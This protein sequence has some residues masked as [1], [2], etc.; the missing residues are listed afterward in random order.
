MINLTTPELVL[1][2]SN[3]GQRNP[4]L[5]VQKFSVVLNE[6]G[7]KFHSFGAIS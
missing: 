7:D 4:F 3:L 6:S 1:N 2:Q 5:N